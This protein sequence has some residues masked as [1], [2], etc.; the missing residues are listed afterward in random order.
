MYTDHGFQ[1]ALAS[2]LGEGG[3]DPRINGVLCCNI[4]PNLFLVVK[5]ILQDQSRYC[6]KKAATLLLAITVNI[7]ATTTTQV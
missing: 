1:E 6:V 3:T 5:T 7:A 4:L 2:L